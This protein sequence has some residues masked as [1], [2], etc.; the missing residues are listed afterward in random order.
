MDESMGEMIGH[1]T[2]VMRAKERNE[3][4]FVKHDRKEVLKYRGTNV[5][6][7]LSPCSATGHGRHNPKTGLFGNYCE[8]RPDLRYLSFALFY[9]HHNVLRST[10][11][12]TDTH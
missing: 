6:L 12:V 5:D 7:P 10:F 2:N 9:T 4:T 3:L 1:W 8:T 11:L